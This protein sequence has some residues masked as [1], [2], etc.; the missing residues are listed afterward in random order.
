MPDDVETQG[1]DAE[2]NT[3]EAP[4]ARPLPL[5]ERERMDTGCLLLMVAGFFGVF[6]LPAF[7]LLGG[8]P[9]ILPLLTLLLVAVLTP[10]INP[11]E[12]W[13]PKAMWI[14]R[15]V[16]FGVIGLILLVGWYLVFMRAVPVLRE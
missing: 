15:G 10:F 2:N 11:V 6:M 8:A 14:G 7:F 16:T 4:P 13:S 12:K 5:K 9:V 1:A 3:P